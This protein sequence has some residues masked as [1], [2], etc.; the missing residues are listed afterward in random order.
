MNKVEVPR[1][2]I[3]KS[4]TNVQLHIL[5]DASSRAYG[6]VAYIR[7]QNEDGSIQVRLVCSKSRVA[8]VSALTLRRLELCGGVIMVNLA[9]KLK[10]ILNIQFDKII[11]WT[12]SEVVLSWIYTDGTYKTFVVNRVASIKRKT[13]P[14]DWRYINTKLNPAD[15][16]SRGILPD[17]LL[18]S[19]SWWEGPDFLK[20]DV[21]E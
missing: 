18:E 4:A 15:V 1:L 5:S 16:I 7:S 6:A 13:K 9:E 2:M 8:P 20:L 17:K 11:Y 12:D 19:N 21:S 10:T 14:K 3:A